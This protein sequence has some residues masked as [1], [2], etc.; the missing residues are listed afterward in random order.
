VRN[1]S[2]T[3][4][5]M[6]DSMRARNIGG[7]SRAKKIPHE[8]GEWWGW[9]HVGRSGPYPPLSGG[10]REALGGAS[11]RGRSWMTSD[12]ADSNAIPDPLKDRFAIPE[13]L[14]D[15][16]APIEDAPQTKDGSRRA[17]PRLFPPDDR[18]LGTA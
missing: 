6:R 2:I 1:A 12:W 8:A 18:A 14:K 13:P 16:F 15:R 3:R 7:V 10:W 4:A 17:D 5:G 9:C 11:F